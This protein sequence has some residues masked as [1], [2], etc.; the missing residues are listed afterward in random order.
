MGFTRDP[1]TTKPTYNNDITDPTGQFQENA[2][3]AER[4][5]NAAKAA[6]Q[7]EY[8]SRFLSA[9]NGQTAGSKPVPADAIIREFFFHS[10]PRTNG[11]G[12]A[13]LV[14]PIAFGRSIGDIVS[15]HTEANAGVNAVTNAGQMSRTGATVVFPGVA[16][17]DI[18]C[19]VHIW[20][21][22]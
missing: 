3:Y 15:I 19:S 2:D 14:W 8:R 4:A 20:G 6:I 1:D 13:T 5:V 12:V 7:A 18:R 11:A 16:N 21:W 17:T 22:D 9:T 10:E